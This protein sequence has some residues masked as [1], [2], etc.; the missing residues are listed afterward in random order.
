MGC[1]PHSDRSN[2]RSTHD[3]LRSSEALTSI[4]RPPPSARAEM[5]ARS[6]MESPRPAT[7]STSP[8][9]RFLMSP[10]A[11]NT[12]LSSAVRPDDYKFID[13]IEGYAGHRPR[14]PVHDNLGS[15][16]SSPLWSP[17]RTG[18]PGRL[19]GNANNPHRVVYLSHGRGVM[20]E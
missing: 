2:I 10:A 18:S 13:T 11:V 7:V 8:R 16:T 17:P 4:W 9:T 12:Q 6:S 20:V 1:H 14:R 3:Q 19:K 5:A 15:G